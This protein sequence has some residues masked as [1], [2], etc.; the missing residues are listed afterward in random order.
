MDD[1]DNERE[2]LRIH[3]E[4]AS[5]KEQVASLDKHKAGAHDMSKVESDYRNADFRTLQEISGQISALRTDMKEW[6]NNSVNAAE[7]R[8][9]AALKSDRDWR[10][11]LPL[12]IAIGLGALGILSGNPAFS[13]LIGGL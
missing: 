1:A 4:L 11:Q 10:R 5:L 9:L 13:R 3:R 12:I 7:T 8:L 2:T 6:T